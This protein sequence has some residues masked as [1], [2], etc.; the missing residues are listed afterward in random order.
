MKNKGPIMKA[1]RQLNGF[2]LVEL[3]VVIAIIG[4]LIALLLPAVQKVREAA[5]RTKCSN[6][7]RQIGMAFT[8]HVTTLGYYPHAGAADWT[9]SVPT[10]VAP[11][12]PAVG[13]QQQAGWAFQILPY[14]DAD[15]VFKVTPL[16]VAAEEGHADVVSFLAG[17]GADLEWTERAGYTAL[18]RATFRDHPEAINALL[19]AGAK[20]Q[21]KDR[22]GP[23]AS[24]SCEKRSAALTP[25]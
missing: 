18:S 11:G 17:H 21:S 1:P 24:A 16:I 23:L 20:C 15:N 7:L 8:N 3:L 19:K 9:T 13:L 4:I 2:T 5:N 14:I 12:Q 25:Q 6:N 10:Y 22:I